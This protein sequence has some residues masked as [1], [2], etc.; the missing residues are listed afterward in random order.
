MPARA[1]HRSDHGRVIGLRTVWG[2]CAALLTIAAAGCD[3]GL[4]GLVPDQPGF[5]ATA[6]TTVDPV[7]TREWFGFVDLHAEGSHLVH[8]RSV[9]LVHLP[10]GLKIDGIH[11]V[12]YREANRLGHGSIGSMSQA[13]V[14]KQFP[15]LPLHPVT[16]IVLT[17][18]KE[19]AWYIVIIVEPERY[20][21]FR[22]SGVQLDYSVGDSR[23]SQIYR[24]QLDVRCGPPG[25]GPS[26]LPSLAP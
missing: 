17:P 6:G 5:S 26:P 22:T 19:S 13:E 25:S 18:G 24:F 16:D 9:E 12:S 14:N 23:G 21:R 8:I 11:A 1:R 4:G 10:N 20:G 7:G 2:G 3:S 15:G